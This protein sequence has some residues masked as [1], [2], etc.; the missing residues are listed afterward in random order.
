MNAACLLLFGCCLAAP[1]LHAALPVQSTFTG[2]KS[3]RT[4]TLKELDPDLPSDW[5][6][7]E[8]LVLEFK[9]SSSQRF[10]LALETATGRNDGENHNIGFVDVTDQPYL[11]IS[12]VSY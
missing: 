2:V 8:V 6:G 9:A 12:F 5:T 7:Y 1:A 11:T 4:W 10:E 3:E